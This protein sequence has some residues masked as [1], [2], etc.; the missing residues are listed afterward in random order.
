MPQEQEP[1]LEEYRKQLQSLDAEDI[2]TPNQSLIIDFFCTDEDLTDFLRAEVFNDMSTRYN[3]WK[4]INLRKSDINNSLT[5][6]KLSELL[7]CKQLDSLE[8]W[9]EILR[10]TAKQQSNPST[11]DRIQAQLDKEN[12]KKKIDIQP[13]RVL[14]NQSGTSTIGDDALISSSPKANSEKDVVTSLSVAG[15]SPNKE[16]D[17]VVPLVPILVGT[18]AGLGMLGAV[19]SNSPPPGGYN[20]SS[21][22]F[23][24]TD[25][26]TQLE[27]EAKNAV[28]ICEHR[29]VIEKAN[30]L[31][32]NDPSLL[33]RKKKI[34]SDSNKAISFLDQ[35]S[36]EGYKY[37]E[38]PSCSWG[39]Q[40]FD[41][42]VDN[43]FRAFI[44]VSKKCSNPVIHYG[45]VE[46]AKGSEFIQTSQIQLGSHI[47]GEVRLPY[48]DSFGYGRIQKVSC[49]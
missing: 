9:A 42:N 17:S 16:I 14:P 28:L 8:T 10:L 24:D 7:D 30:S 39:Q 3:A 35:P 20:S 32:L 26:L 41:K 31:N 6:D 19:L 11:V 43:A 18:I 15:R 13:S 1:A 46:T 33:A 23:D 22:Y 49:N 21:S 2:T 12:L 37:W 5:A 38:D 40:W 36:Q 48:F 27:V 4:I 44:A 29:P 34:I 25:G 45:I 47:K